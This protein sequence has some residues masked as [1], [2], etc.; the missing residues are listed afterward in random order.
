[1]TK[2]LKAFSWR[3]FYPVNARRRKLNAEMT[4][5]FSKVARL[6][7]QRAA[8]DCTTSSAFCCTILSDALPRG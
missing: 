7:L 4:G 6:A 8:G 1:M 3:A 2:C 5:C